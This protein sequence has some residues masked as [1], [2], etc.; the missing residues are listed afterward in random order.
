[1]VHV[2]HKGLIF[3]IFLG[4]FH[5]HASD[6]FSF[7]KAKKD[8]LRVYA[9]HR[10][11]LYCGCKYDKHGFVDWAS[12][13]YEPQKNHKRARR[14]EI[15]HIVPAAEFGR[16][17]PCWREP[18][19]ERK[20]GRKYKGRKCCEKIDARF[21][22]MYT[23]PMNL[24]PAI[25][26]VNGDR[27]D[28]SFSYVEGVQGYGQCQL[29]IDHK[30]RKIY[31]PEQARGLIGRTYLYMHRTYGLVLSKQQMQLF[32]AWDKAYPKTAWESEREARILALRSEQSGR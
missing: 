6:P 30:A 24:A 5:S 4:V 27:R 18:I 23:D 11:T 8:I 31:P 15:E 13:G 26:E 22:A 7:A 17:L 28:Y 29:L 3:L 20:N 1:M 10:V 2:L 14:I 19:C 12:C 9:T 25:G 32:Q 16:Q 21:K